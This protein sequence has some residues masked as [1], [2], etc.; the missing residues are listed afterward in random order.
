MAP[1]RQIDLDVVGARC[2]VAHRLELE[3]F[4]P[5]IHVEGLQ[6][7]QHTHALHRLA[8]AILDRDSED[9]GAELRRVFVSRTAELHSNGGQY[10]ISKAVAEAYVELEAESRKPGKDFGELVRQRRKERGLSVPICDKVLPLRVV[11]TQIASIATETE[12]A[13][14]VDNT[15]SHAQLQLMYAEARVQQAICLLEEAEICGVP[16]RDLEAL[17]AAYLSEL[18]TLEA[19][20]AASQR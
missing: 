12:V 20:R 16:I 6:L 9:V 1:H 7:D 15:Q 18:R 11:C 17:E 19:A 8:T 14:N 4:C 10:D 13:A 3:R 5:H 2:C